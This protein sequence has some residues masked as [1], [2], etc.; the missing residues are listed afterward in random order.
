[1]RNAKATLALAAIG[2]LTVA[3]FAP[4]ASAAP[5]PVPVPKVGTCPQGYSASFNTCRPGPNAH[6][7]VIK[8]GS[9]CPSG[10]YT[11]WAY[12]VSTR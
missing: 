8:Q 6:H 9:F 1:M 3:V 5:R 4:L 7:A 12:C 10:Y 2:L 11:S